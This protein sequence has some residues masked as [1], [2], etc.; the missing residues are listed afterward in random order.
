MIFALLASGF[1]FFIK[2]KGNLDFSYIAVVL[3]SSYVSALV[4]LNWG[5]G[6]LA[7]FGLALLFAMPFT[8]LVLALSERL[9]AFY[10]SIGTMTLYMLV[11][12]LAYNLDGIT[13]GAFGL[14]GI[15][16]I[17]I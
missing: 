3:F 8:L 5:L 11:Y 4:N 6:F 7:S 10:F 14:S 15:K 12:Q 1:R 9:N 13:G 2:L 17:L 16:R